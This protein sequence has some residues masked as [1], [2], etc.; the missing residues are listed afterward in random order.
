M[1]GLGA[2]GEADLP[3]ACLSGVQVYSLQC[4]DKALGN[5]AFNHGVNKFHKH[6]LSYRLA[7]VA[8]SQHTK[9]PN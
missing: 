8:T 4:A 7:R 3:M 2:R 6:A 5:A 1:H 9:L